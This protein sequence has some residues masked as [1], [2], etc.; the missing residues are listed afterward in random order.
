MQIYHSLLKALDKQVPIKDDK[1]SQVKEIINCNIVLQNPQD[2]YLC[3]QHRKYDESYAAAQLAWYADAEPQSIDGIYFYDPTQWGRIKLWNETLDVNSNYGLYI[4]KEGQLDNAVLR[5]KANP[6]SRQ[7]IILMNRPD[8][9]LSATS[10]HICTTSIQFL[11]RH[12]QLVMITS[13]RSQEV[14]IGTYDINFFQLLQEMACLYLQE[15]Y[16]TLKVGPHFHNVGSF[17]VVEEHWD[18]VKQIVKDPK[19]SKIEHI[20]IS[21]R[22]EATKISKNLGSTEKALRALFLETGPLSDETIKQYFVAG[23]GAY[24]KMINDIAKR[25]K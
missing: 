21:S 5:L 23:M 6:T 24:N 13:M 8:V 4:Y 7:A 18:A 20:P 2:R 3:F 14:W 15:R 16:E 25:L 19:I 1:G 22:L 10:D 12:N 9:S 17:H 11:I